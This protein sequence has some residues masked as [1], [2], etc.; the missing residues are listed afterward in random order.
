MQ[1]PGEDLSPYRAASSVSG[2]VFVGQKT[3]KKMGVL[4]LWNGIAEA[5]GHP[6]Q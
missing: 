6:A 1:V 5:I 2:R 3:G 4:N